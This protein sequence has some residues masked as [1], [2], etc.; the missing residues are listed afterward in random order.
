M[1]KR[2]LL[3]WNTGLLP[4]LQRMLIT[5]YRSWNAPPTE[6]TYPSNPE[7]SNSSHPD[8]HGSNVNGRFW[9]RVAASVEPSAVWKVLLSHNYV[10]RDGG[11]RM[12]EP[13]S[14]SCC[15]VQQKNRLNSS[16]C[17][18]T[19]KRQ[20]RRQN[21]SPCYLYS[22][23]STPFATKFRPTLCEHAKFLALNSQCYH[24]FTFI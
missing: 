4:Q 23:V 16:Q 20:K 22:T 10:H 2:R 8:D 5:Y 18:N 1:R 17:D 14:E 7:S 13:L 19:G 6:E 24:L 3:R 21:C 12:P 9:L 15:D 11:K